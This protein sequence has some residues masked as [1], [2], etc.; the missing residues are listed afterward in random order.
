LGDFFNFGSFFNCRSS[1]EFWAS[2]SKAKNSLQILKKIGWAT[3]WAIFSKTHLVPL[4]ATQLPT[5]LEALTIQALSTQNL[6]LHQ[7]LFNT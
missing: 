4:L 2:L 5:V 1:P 3:F 6:P 7:I